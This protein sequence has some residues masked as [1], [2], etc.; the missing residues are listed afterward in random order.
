[1]EIQQ[2]QSVSTDLAPGGSEVE[3]CWAK[4]TTKDLNAIQAFRRLQGSPEM[5]N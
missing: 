2:H 1:V 4:H 5:K 3:R